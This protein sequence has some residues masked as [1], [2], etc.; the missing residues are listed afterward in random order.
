M[1]IRGLFPKGDNSKVPYLSDLAL[2]T[3][4]PFICLTETHLT[5]AVLDAEVAVRGYDIFRSDRVERSHGGVA[6][7]VR[8]DI[9]VKTSM[10][11]S[12]SYSYLKFHNFK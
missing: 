2:T 8:K 9:A 12:N 1:N 10:K 7:Y 11:D 3:N 6:I 5:S 4:A